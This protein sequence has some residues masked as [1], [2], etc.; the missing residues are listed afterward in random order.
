M[1]YVISPQQGYFDEGEEFLR[2]NGVT[3]EAILSSKLLSDR[4]IVQRMEVSGDCADIRRCFTADGKSLFEAEITDAGDTAVALIHYLPGPLNRTLLEVYHNHPVLMDF[5]LQYVGPEKR[6]LRV[7]VIG[8][9]NAISR[10]GT[11]TQE[12]V[13][14][15]IEQL[16]SYDP[17]TGRPF[18]D[19]TDRQREV[20]QTAI[21]TGYYDVPRNITHEDI[22]EKLDCTPGTVGQHLRRI[23]SKI[24][25]SAFGSARANDSSVTPRSES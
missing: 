24:M 4:T 3:P 19:L 10:F 23:E 5:P 2:E 12:R 18:T 7:S 9:E 25:S 16:G 14:V 1:T 17:T 8:S 11:E 15:S 13:D 22:A 21:E 20:L 6:D